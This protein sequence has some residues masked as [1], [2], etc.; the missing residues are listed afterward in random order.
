MRTHTAH[1]QDDVDRLQ[2]AQLLGDKLLQRRAHDGHGGH[3]CVREVQDNNGL[4]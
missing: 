3:C 4:R 2:A 1:V